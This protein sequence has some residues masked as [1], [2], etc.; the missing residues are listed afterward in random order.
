MNIDIY[1]KNLTAL[2][3]IN[4]RLHYRLSN[5]TE[6]VKYDVTVSENDALD[7]NIIEKA[8]KAK[9][10]Q[11]PLDEVA[12]QLT[13]FEPFYRYPFLAFYG[14]GNGLF[15][16]AT[17]HRETHQKII[18]IEPELEILFIALHFLDFSEDI[19]SGRLKIFLDE[20]VDYPTIREYVGL[21]KIGQFLKTYILH[22][23][24]SYYGKY[25]LGIM[26]TNKIFTEA[27]I[28][29]I[30]SHGNDA[31]DSLI[32][33]DHFWNNV[34]RMLR[35][36]RFYE[37]TTKQNTN[38]AII[39]STGPSLTKQLPLL[40]EIQDYVTIISV[41]ASMPI[42]EKWG[43]KPDIVTSIERVEETA[44]FF[45]KTSAEFQKDI[46]FVSS[47]L[48]H[49]KIYENIQDGQLVIAMRPFGYMQVLEFNDYGYVGIGMS[50]AN[51]AYEVAFLM[52]FD[53]AVFIG[54]DLAYGN[55]GNSHATHHVY[56]EDEVKL[57]DDDSYV[58]AYGG[59]GLVRTTLVWKLFMGFFVSAISESKGFTIA[60]NCTEGGARIDGTLELSFEEAMKVLVNKEHKKEMI[61]LSTPSEA[62]YAKLM[63]EAKEKLS[64]LLKYAKKTKKMVEKLFLDVATE[65]DKLEKLNKEN[66]LSKVNFK[67]ISK[68]LKDIDAIK[69][70][71]PGDMFRRLFWDI[72]Q[73]YIMSQELDLAAIAVK[74]S[75]TKEEQEIKMVEFLFG[76]K[77]WLFMLAG[78]IDAVIDIMEKNKKQIFSEAKKTAKYLPKEEKA[79]EESKEK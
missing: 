41:D 8:S 50:S 38:V 79:K 45:E 2:K 23:S 31:T 75:K 66:E 43:I 55:D 13:D 32:G 69:D 6:N 3:K 67:K 53:H 71:L 30:R 42:L 57:K 19:E 20:D 44:K 47:A 7:V 35:N 5:V 65:C 62:E 22:I 37:L 58:T 36:P 11:K 21:S 14:F 51:M 17:L 29:F 56:G 9:M 70:M 59:K 60:Y 1:Y 33:L 28:H 52:N 27:I 39:V 61:K 63:T 18:V 73:S 34:P 77:P 16:K 68:L 76:H 24:N 12:R 26:R 74:P 48:Q 25:Q 54:Q 49:K 72:V 4:P 15:L 64:E 40:K 46:V 10:Y 78:G